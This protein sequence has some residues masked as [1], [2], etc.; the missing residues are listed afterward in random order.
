MNNEEAAAR[1][2]S[3]TDSEAQS[4]ESSQSKSKSKDHSTPGLGPWSAVEHERFLLGIQLYPEGPWKAVADVVQTR[5]AKQ[6]QTHMQ[7]CKEK[8]LRHRRRRNEALRGVI[9]DTTDETIRQTA[10]NAAAAAATEVLR[11]S[12][13]ADNLRISALEPIP[14]D[15][16]TPIAVVTSAMPFSK[17]TLTW[18]EAVDFFWMLVASSDSTDN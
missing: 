16:T 13:H 18:C 17:Q 2:T 8:I 14:F 4:S 1:S 6:A 15:A 9:E 12:K 10:F 7:K 3:S 11:R 5:N